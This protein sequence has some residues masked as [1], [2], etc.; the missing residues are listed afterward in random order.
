MEIFQ[1]PDEMSNNPSALCIRPTVKK[2]I[3]FDQNYFVQHNLSNFECNMAF[4]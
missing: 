1:G 2:K 4:N 3:K